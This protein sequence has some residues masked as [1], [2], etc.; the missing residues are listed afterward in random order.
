MRQTVRKAGSRVVAGQKAAGRARTRKRLK[1]ISHLRRPQE[2]SLEQWQVALRRQ[3]S[4][5]Q[6]LKLKNVGAERIFSEFL[7]ANPKTKGEYR[8]AIRG[9]GLGENYC[10]CPDFA[11]NTLGTCKHIEY[12]LSKCRRVP[13]GRLAMKRGFIPAYSE[14]FLRYGAKREVMFRP[15]TDCPGPGPQGRGRV[16]RQERPAHAG[17]VPRLRETDPG[18]LRIGARGPLLRGHDRLCGGGPG[19]G[20]F[21]GPRG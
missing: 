13:G 1:R 5:E 7:V 18:D 20:P 12:V 17:R 4:L 14:I 21:E 16:F 2:M 10:S 15:G 3:I 11:V 19:S 9:Q 8:V 6:G